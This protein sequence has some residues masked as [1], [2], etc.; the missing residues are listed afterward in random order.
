MFCSVTAVFCVAWR[1]ASE[2]VVMREISMDMPW[3]GSGCRLQMSA[4][5]RSAA[6]AGAYMSVRYC[7]TVRPVKALVP[8]ARCMYSARST[9]SSCMCRASR[10]AASTSW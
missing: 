8:T 7:G 5:G 3:S 4:N 1:P 9:R 10:E 6:V 2:P